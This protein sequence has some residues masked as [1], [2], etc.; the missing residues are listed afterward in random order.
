MESKRRLLVEPRLVRDAYL[1]R[2]RVHLDEV[3]KQ[4]LSGQIG[5]VGVDTGI[6]PDRVLIEFLK[7]GK[8]QRGHHG[9]AR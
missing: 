4:C 2:L 1:K 6:R 7:H 8:A 9:R 5:H 3:R